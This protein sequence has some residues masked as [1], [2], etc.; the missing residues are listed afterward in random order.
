MT[1]QKP[2]VDELK[3]GARRFLYPRIVIGLGL[4]AV[5]ALYIFWPR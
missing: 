3:Q 1:I 2:D 5:M 4:L